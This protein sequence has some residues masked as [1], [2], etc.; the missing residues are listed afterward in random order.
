MKTKYSQVDSRYDDPEGIKARLIKDII[1]Y[2]QLFLSPSQARRITSIL[3]LIAGVPSQRITE[4]TGSCERSIRDWKKQISA[5]DANS[6]LA[7]GKG[8][9]RKSKFTDIESQ[10]L[11]E[12]ENG[13][14]HTQQQIADMVKE[15]FG[16]SVSLMAVSR[17]LKK[18]ASGS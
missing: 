5:G 10:V 1:T 2:L 12:L 13:N 4:W 9:G 17:F 14:Y 16:I 15:K 6:L 18:T 7:Q 11:E 3:L 8:A